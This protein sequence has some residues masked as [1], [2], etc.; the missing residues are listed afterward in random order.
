MSYAT[1]E[2][3]LAR[4]PAFALDDD[5]AVEAVERL[6]SEA[7]ADVDARLRFAG[8]PPGPAF[9][10]A[11]DATEATGRVFPGTGRHRLSIDPY[12]DEIVSVT[13][14]GL[15]EAPTFE[16]RGGMLVTVD[17]EGLPTPTVV[18]PVGADVTVTARWGAATVP[19]AIVTAVLDTVQARYVRS[20]ADATKDRLPEHTDFIG[21]AVEPYRASRALLE[22]W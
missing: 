6:I 20:Y 19:G 1:I 21:P 16:V 22:M 2:E 3:F 11:S 10:I 9:P 15:D 8:D 13:V 17:E 18:W 12:V 14:E 4:T 5:A 7:S